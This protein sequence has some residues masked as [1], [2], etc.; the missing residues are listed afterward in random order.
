MDLVPRPLS[1]LIDRLEGRFGAFLDNLFEF[2]RIFGDPLLDLVGRFPFKAKSSCVVAEPTALEF[3]PSV[4]VFMG[5]L[6]L[7]RSAS[8]S[9]ASSSLVAYPSWGLQ[10]S[11]EGHFLG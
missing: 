11:F 10:R 4:V 2:Y 5:D 7:P 8:L 6:F 3:L 1:P 9:R